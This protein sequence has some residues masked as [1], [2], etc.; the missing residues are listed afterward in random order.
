MSDK[1]TSTLQ[2]YIDS[3]SGAVQSAIGSLT[4]DASDQVCLHLLSTHAP[5]HHILTEPRTPVKPRKTKPNSRTRPPTQPPKSATT[6]LRPREQSQKTTPTAPKALGT[7]PSVP[8]RKLLEAL[9]VQRFVSP[10][11]SHPAFY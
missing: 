10:T 9:L 8:P 5:L 1:N 7:K 11:L 3:A 6:P 2:S 4:G